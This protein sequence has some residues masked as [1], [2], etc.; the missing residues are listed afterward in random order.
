MFCTLVG[1]YNYWSTGRL[2]ASYHTFLILAV[3][4]TCVTYMYEPSKWPSSHKS[5]CSSVVRASNRCVEGLGLTP[6]E[7]SHYFVFCLTL[8]AKWINICLISFSKVKIDHLFLFTFQ[9]LFCGLGYWRRC[10]WL[11]NAKTQPLPWQVVW[12]NDG[13][14]ARG[15][16]RTTHIWNS[17]RS[18]G[19]FLPDGKP[20]INS[21][22][23]FA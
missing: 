8:V 11:Q 15:A 18:A 10:S 6:I 9:L 14:L 13:V 3:C 23:W 19:G 4:M 20:W 21:V 22:A 16:S 17:T 12:D 7:N 2:M 5:P 1:C